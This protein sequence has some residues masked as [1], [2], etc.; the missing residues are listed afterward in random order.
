MRWCI[1]FVALGCGSSPATDAP[2]D[3][4]I[5]VAD[6]YADA[7]ID[8]AVATDTATVDVVEETID[9]AAVSTACDQYAAAFCAKTVAC[10]ALSWKTTFGDDTRCRARAKLA[11]M[12]KVSA[13][14]SGATAAATTAC[15]DA[16]K[17][18]GCETLLG[19]TPTACVPRGSLDDG[20]KCFDFSQCKSGLCAARDRCGVCA[21]ETKPG[22]ACRNGTCSPG[23]AC[24]GGNC[25]ALRARGDTCGSGVG[26]CYPDS[27]CSGGKCVA[28]P[29]VGE[30]CSGTLGTGCDWAGGF[31]CDDAS[32]K[33]APVT[34]ANVGESC[35][36]F[37]FPF[38]FCAAGSH[39][40]MGK[41][42]TDVMDGAACGSTY[43]PD[44]AWPALCVKGTCSTA[45]PAWCE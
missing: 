32:K 38:V 37:T 9:A 33:C 39:C 27:I 26:A 30:T 20:A 7:T 15:A 8:S 34:V 43:G 11:C 25:F 18:G 4:T 17:A 1:A 36:L 14:G 41:C 45:S 31:Y 16:I 29:A 6:A 2:A 40:D 10:L 21:A 22:D 35:T 13:P 19:K 23:Q 24:S 44:C 28:P 12:A 5:D 42:V 3:A